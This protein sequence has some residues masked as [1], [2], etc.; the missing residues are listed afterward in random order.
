MEAAF[1][2]L[3]FVELVPAFVKQTAVHARMERFHPALEHLGKIG[4]ARDVADRHAFFAEQ[5][6]RAAGG[7][8][9][10]ALLFQSARER[11]HA[12]LVRDGDEGAG[13][14]HADVNRDSLNRYIDPIHDS[15]FTIH[16]TDRVSDRSRSS[17]SGRARGSSRWFR[18]TLC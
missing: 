2:R 8:D 3:L 14:L 6:G 17:P 16:V 12:F 15:R 1:L 11:R 18:K 9:I 7:N 10:D 4:E 5:V 13:D